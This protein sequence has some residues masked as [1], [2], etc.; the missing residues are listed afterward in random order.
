MGQDHKYYDVNDYLSWKRSQGKNNKVAPRPNLLAATNWLRK[1]FDAR[2]TKWAA[3]GS[4]AMLCLGARRE[5][6][7]IHIVYEDKDFQRIRMKL[8]TDPRVRLPKDMNSMFSS[9]LLISTGPKYNDVGCTENAD[10]E[11]EMIPPGSHGTPPSDTLDDNQAMLSLNLG[12]KITNI[13]GLNIIYLVNT[14]VHLCTSPDLLWDPKKDLVW[15]C[16]RYGKEIQSI[17][18]QLNARQVKENFLG[19]AFFSAL[20]A[21]EQRLC[22]HVLLE[23][24][25]PPSMFLTPAPGHGQPTGPAA[26]PPIPSHASAP[27]LKDAVQE[28]SNY[29]RPPIHRKSKTVLGAP[30]SGSITQA[31]P[32]AVTSSQTKTTR[33]S[34]SRYRNSSARSTPRASLNVSP[35]AATARPTQSMIEFRSAHMQ[36][37]NMIYQAQS[38]NMKNLSPATNPQVVRTK[39][40][41]PRVGGHPSNAQAVPVFA[42]KSPNTPQAHAQMTP[43]AGSKP[44]EIKNGP[45]DYVL[46]S[47]SHNNA[48][49]SATSAQS[50]VVAHA[51]PAHN[52]MAQRNSMLP[53][54][55][56]MITDVPSVC[57]IEN[58]KADAPSKGLAVICPEGL[59]LTPPKATIRPEQSRPAAPTM[60]DKT[61]GNS[62]DFVF[63][64]DVVSPRVEDFA[65]AVPRT[66]VVELPA[67]NDPP[68][69]PALQRFDTLPDTPIGP[70]QGPAQPSPM[71]A[72]SHSPVSPQTDFITL[73]S[74]IQP[75]KV[76]LM[77]ETPKSGPAP[78]ASKLAPS[79]PVFDSLPPSL[80]IGF[81]GVKH[82]SSAEP[83][84][85]TGSQSSNSSNPP[86]ALSNYQCCYYSPPNSREASPNTAST[87]EP[88]SRHP[89]PIRGPVYKAYT[90]PLTPPLQPKPE[91]A[92]SQQTH[93][94]RYNQV[95]TPPALVSATRPTPQQGTPVPIDRASELVGRA[96]S[97][98]VLQTGADIPQP[99]KIAKV[100]HLPNPLATNPPTPLNVSHVKHDSHH[101]QD[102]QAV[103]ASHNV[104]ENPYFTG[105]PQVQT[106][107][108][109]SH[110]TT[111]QYIAFST[112]HA[113]E[114]EPRR[115]ASL[116]QRNAST[117]SNTSTISHDSEKL[118]KE[119]QIHLPSFDDG[120]GTQQKS[121]EAE[122]EL[123]NSSFPPYDEDEHGSQY[124]L[125]YPDFG[126]KQGK[127]MDEFYFS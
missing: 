68:L 4:L 107:S 33:D 115:Q 121:S 122:S 49:P 75:I 67:H 5:I 111:P 79:P 53:K 27:S 13:K 35:E 90:P 70:P 108:P 81:R 29:L 42:H 22:Y 71:S 73:A 101:M 54:N 78:Q 62:K 65:Q 18:G 66:E 96:Y 109:P 21:E 38:M 20:P 125:R 45:H 19:T 82:P 37:H 1:F 106:Y 119:Y 117:E 124:H 85:R 50:H 91:S 120:F 94:T 17:R 32:G 23:K 77:N 31:S 93:P 39:K 83:R 63:E 80:M 84:T 6:P 102:H 110:S 47:H 112:Q 10:I 43:V 36:Q 126:N 41:L 58:S 51:H 24:E 8:Q 69:Q 40:S 95:P 116:H 103:S 59:Y 64:L 104:P 57:Q 34:R 74:T 72:F 76:D 87:P 30:P 60:Q 44:S 2:K 113:T 92:Q 7:D 9:K 89:S 26:R 88:N 127:V 123:K 56:G 86:V 14:T 12:G 105:V 55:H 61:Q 118:A 46:Q 11:V 99:L 52:T 48:L 3:M 25:P 15:L 97:P 100:S 98:T 28:H 114:A 16:R